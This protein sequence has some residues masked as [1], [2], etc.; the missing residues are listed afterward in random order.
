MAKPRKMLCDLEADYTQ[1][2]MRLIETQSKA[3]LANWALN[4]AEANYLPIYTRHFPTDQRPR[5]AIQAARSWLAGDIKLPQV[6]P[7]ILAAH[8]AAREAEAVPSAQ[9]AAR[10]IGQAASTIHSATH[11]LGL[12]FYGSAAVAYESFGTQASIDIYERVMEE[13]VGRVTKA[14]RSVAVET[15]PNPAKINWNC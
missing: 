7:F 13:E 6:K 10:A 5:Q 8:A 3:T 12:A 15:E 4:Y 9:A 14:L 1:T 11:S 2:L